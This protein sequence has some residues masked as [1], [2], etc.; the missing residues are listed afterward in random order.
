MG[1]TV[2]YAILLT[3]R[4]KDFRESMDKKEALVY[5]ILAVTVSILTSGSVLTVVGFLLG[6]ISTHGVLS[7]LGYFLGKGT[8][9]SL[10]IVLFVLPGLLYIF[11]RAFIKQLKK[12]KN[13]GN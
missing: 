7:Q 12:I 3:D 4:Y 5:T 1:A 8:L 9:C 13:G 2:D 11:D 6:A 10:A